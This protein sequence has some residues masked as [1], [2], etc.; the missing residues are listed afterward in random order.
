MLKF[1]RARYFKV[2][3]YFIKLKNIIL[4][5]KHFGDDN[6]LEEEFYTTWNDEAYMHGSRKE[7]HSQSYNNYGAF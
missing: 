6:I 3:E 1:L 4:W 2:F 5:R 7:G